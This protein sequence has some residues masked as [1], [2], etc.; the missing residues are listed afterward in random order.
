[1]RA[2]TVGGSKFERETLSLLTQNQDVGREKC[3]R[4]GRARLNNKMET[5][6]R[7]PLRARKREELVCATHE[8]AADGRCQG[9]VGPNIEYSRSTRQA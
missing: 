9:N 3:L 6:G 7:A 1:M 5:T 2:E 8:K 4:Q